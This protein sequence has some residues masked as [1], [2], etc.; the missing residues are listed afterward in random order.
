[1]KTAKTAGTSIEVYL[2]QICDSKDVFTPFSEPEEGHLPRNYLGIFNPAPELKKKLKLWWSG[3][4]VDFSASFSD[5]VT[6]RKYF[7]HIPAWQIANRVPRQV[8]DNYYKF[9]VERNPW[10]KVVSGL[11]WYNKKY[12]TKLS[13]DQYLSMCSSRIQARKHGV[14]ICPFNLYNYSDPITGKQLV[15]KII[16]YENLAP[17]LEKIF[18]CLGI[19]TP[20]RF[21][22]YAKSGFR[23]NRSYREVFNSAQQARVEKLFKGEI[24]LHGYTF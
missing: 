12:R 23:D 18:L 6:L 20:N 19:D 9:C 14:G 24:E 15:D 5:F 4:K 22:V 8:W 2:S 10:D 16:F 13:I 21:D 1:M 11:N 3:Y 7:H 17:E